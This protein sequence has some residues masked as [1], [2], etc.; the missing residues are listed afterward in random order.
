MQADFF[1]KNVQNEHN[2]VVFIKFS[3]KS[4]PAALPILSFLLWLFPVVTFSSLPKRTC[5][6]K[7][8]AFHPSG[9]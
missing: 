6:L 5:A 1:H 3:L 9:A 8:Y 4:V 2:F 7:A